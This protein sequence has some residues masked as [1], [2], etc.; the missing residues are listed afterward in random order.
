MPTVKNWGAEFKRS[1]TSVEN[2]PS[3]GRPKTTNTPEIII[4]VHDIVSDDTRVKVCETS[5]AVG[6]SEEK[7]QN[8]LH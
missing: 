5:E 4:K 6:I 8:I 1:Y 2:R 7:V 3:E